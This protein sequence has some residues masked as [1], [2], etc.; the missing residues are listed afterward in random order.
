[1]LVI[2]S[3]YKK[4]SL[5]FKILAI[6]A[7]L[8]LSFTLLF[9]KLEKNIVAQNFNNSSNAIID[10]G[11]SYNKTDSQDTVKFI[12]LKTHKISIIVLKV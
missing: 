7:L 8:F 4:R 1:M 5:F 9:V 2:S 12:S 10:A 11:D 3:M 6:T